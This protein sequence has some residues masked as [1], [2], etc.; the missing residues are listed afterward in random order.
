MRHNSGMRHASSPAHPSGTT[1]TAGA[2]RPRARRGEGSRLRE[3]I[4]AAAAGMLAA[5]GETAD[6][7]LRSVARSVGVA[8]TS[9]YPH[10]RD[11][12]RL[13]LAVKQVFL[14]EFGEAL[15]AAARAAG[16]RPS[17][18][19]RARTRAYY[20]YG[21]R[22]PGRYKVMF[23]SQ[24]LNLAFGPDDYPGR[25]VFARVRDDV[26]AATGETGAAADLTATHLWTAIHGI[27]TLRL[28]RP[29]FPWPDLDV[30]LDDL[31]GRLLRPT[32]AGD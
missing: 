16:E 15:E 7:S 9:I 18:R 25:E 17:D 27:V 21:M 14:T 24:P 8:A 5:S 4:V 30:E 26:A 31:I 6:L 3:E 10:F 23:S 11:L 12:D 32:P 29:R 20:D 22:N 28:V 13:I 1:A 19:V 2:R